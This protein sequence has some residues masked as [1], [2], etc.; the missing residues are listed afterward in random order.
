M[1]SL[2]EG[3]IKWAFWPPE[4]DLSV[5]ESHQTSKATGIWISYT[6]EQEVDLFDHDH[7]D[8]IDGRSDVSEDD[9]TSND[10]AAPGPGK[11][12]S[13][14]EE[15]SGEDSDAPPAAV[16]VTT[17]RF[18]ALMVSDDSEEEDDDEEEG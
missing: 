12:D 4:T 5:I 8:S 1:R 3:K 10:D 2:A 17:S 18:G 14:K 6:D 13:D 9:Q 15:D 16:K 7:G 11:E